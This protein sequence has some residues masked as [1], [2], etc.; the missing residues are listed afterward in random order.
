METKDPINLF[1]KKAAR[2]MPLYIYE[3]QD[4][5]HE[6]LMSCAPIHTGD[7]VTVQLSTGETLQNRRVKK[8]SHYPSLASETGQLLVAFIELS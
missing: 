5:K 1:I 2:V 3:L 4:Y 8:V 6:R 7:F